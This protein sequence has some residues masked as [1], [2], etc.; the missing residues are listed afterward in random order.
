MKIISSLSYLVHPGKNLDNPPEVLGTMIPLQGSMFDLLSDVFIR[1]DR[2][3]DMPIRFTKELDGTQNNE[4][5]N[6]VIGFMQ[7]PSLNIGKHLA[8]RL[9]DY[10]TNRSGLGLL[11]LIFGR[12]DKKAEYK[13]VLSRFPA[14]RGI[15]AEADEAG[16][17]LEF[18]ERIFMK[19]ATA[20]KAALYKG[21]SFVS[22]FWSGHAID[23]QINAPNYQIATYWIRD[24]LAS[25]HKT[26]SAAGTKRFA[27]AL[28]EASKHARSVEVQHELIGLRMLA[29][30]KAG[31]S[32]S[33]QSLMDD[34]GLS[35][36]AHLA[37]I[38]E[39]AYEDLVSDQ[40]VLDADEFN[41]HAA[42]TSVELHTGG[43][44]LAP[45]DEFNRVFPREAVDREE[46]L[47]R[48]SA[49]GRIIDER[50]RGRK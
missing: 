21:S 2:E 48:F 35:E 41:R 6:R 4:V 18:L 30:G 49:E 45:A 36:Q 14:D 44:L 42:F 5:R 10:T 29:G 43:M 37:I 13:L 33:I 50:V 22:G 1:S 40:F 3:C 12:D 47:Y 19:S 34:F 11:F 20:Y 24:F 7:T 39:L 23:K 25:D 38:N 32:I 28:R 16:L 46:N 8:N 15:L 9:R 26:T 17:K 27:I 31:K